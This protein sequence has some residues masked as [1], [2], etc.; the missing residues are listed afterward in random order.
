M[1]RALCLTHLSCP[2]LMNWSIIHWGGNQD[3]IIIVMKLFLTEHTT[4]VKGHNIIIKWCCGEIITYY[5][6]AVLLK[7][8]NW[9][10]QQTS[11]KGFV[12]LNP[13]SKPKKMNVHHEHQW[14]LWRSVWKSFCTKSSHADAAGKDL[15]VHFFGMIRI[16]IRDPRSLGSWCIKGTDESV[17]R[18]DSSVL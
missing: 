14:Q 18:V 3:I 16:W 1:V 13:N 8:P 9:A 4:P 15:R 17:T 7:S 6:W 5:T 12:M 11:A 10:S 2:L